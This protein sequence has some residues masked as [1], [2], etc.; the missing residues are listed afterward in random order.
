MREVAAWC[1]H[2]RPE[3]DEWIVRP[4]QTLLNVTTE[5]IYGVPNFRH[6]W[7]NQFQFLRSIQG[8]QYDKTLIEG[9]NAYKN[10]WGEDTQTVELLEPAIELQLQLVPATNDPEFQTALTQL[11]QGVRDA[12]ISLATR[13]ISWGALPNAG[14]VGI[15]LLLAS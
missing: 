8:Q 5:A 13:S 12:K 6:V 1:S 7:A 9:I 4:F 15:F 14:I 10:T 11:S 2:N 3:L